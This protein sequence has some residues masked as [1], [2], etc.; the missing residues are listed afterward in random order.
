MLFRRDHR[1]RVE[2]CSSNYPRYDRNPNTGGDIPTRGDRDDG[3]AVGASRS[4]G[5]VAHHPAGHPAMSGL[6][7]GQ[8]P[9]RNIGTLHPGQIDELRFT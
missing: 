9:P 1:I 2:V 5:T 4:G 3:E 6:F 8:R 7:S